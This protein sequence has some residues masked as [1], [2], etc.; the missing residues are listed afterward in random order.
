MCR[1]KSVLNNLDNFPYKWIIAKI[2]PMHK[3]INLREIPNYISDKYS[4][5]INERQ[6]YDT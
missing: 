4:Q 2:I 6:I 1:Q 3:S 5:K